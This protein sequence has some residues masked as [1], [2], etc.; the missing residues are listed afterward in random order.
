[1]KKQYNLAIVGF[2]GMANW[3]REKI[4]EIDGIKVKGTF[5]INPA[6]QQFAAEKGL[7][8]YESLDAVLAD[9]EIDIV[10]CATPNDVHKEVVIKTLRAGKTAVSEKPVTLSSADLAEMI[11]AAQETGK[12]FTVHQNRRWDEDFLTVKRI[13][14]NNELGE[15]FRIE[16]RVHGSR[17]IG[18][19]RR[20]AA[21]GGGMVLDWGVHQFD[22]L[23][24]M[25]PYKVK[26]VHAMLTN[27]TVDDV[28]DGFT[29]HLEFENGI[30]ALVEACGNNFITLPRWY[31]LGNNGSAVIP[32]WNKVGT[33]TRVTDWVKD[34]STHIQAGA[35][36]T[37]T[38]AP[39]TDETIK[40]EPLVFEQSDIRD[41]YRNVMATME[42]REQIAV[43]L[44]EVAR[45]MRL[46]EAVFE[47]AKTKKV[48]EFE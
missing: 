4:G 46:M 22:Q 9:P 13:Y 12:L 30:V 47:S 7:L 20:E 8:P 36:L 31:V 11:A 21:H 40:T 43:K 37:K 25:I 15:L 18:G 42:G 34:D 10:L 39:R 14:E 5:D 28:D 35:G 2:G 24:Q 26:R 32:D 44:P 41:F 48:V 17:G 38:M 6:R 19:W 33:M 1:M 23:L 27:I 45:V 29:A 16:S 3:H